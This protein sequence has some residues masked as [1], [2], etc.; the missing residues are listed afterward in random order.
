LNEAVNRDPNFALAWCLLARAHDDVYHQDGDRT[1]SRRVAAENALQHALQLRPDLG[2][3]HL[4]E[5]FHLLVTTRD[6]P[7]VRNELEIARSTLPNSASLYGLLAKVDARQGRWKDALQDLEKALSLDPKNVGFAIERY[8]LYQFHRQ[9]DE[10]SRISN[11]LV[12]TGPI[13][14]S[15]AIEKALTA[16]QAAGDT[17]PF[18]ALLDEPVGPLRDIG[19]ATLLKIYCAFADR[20][21]PRAEQILAQDPKHEFEGGDIRFVCRDWVLGWIKKMQSD[22]GAA[23]A[24]FANARPVQAA[25]V[26]KM[27]DDP[28]PLIMLALTDAAL[29]RKQEAFAEA[30]K[31]MKMRPLSRDAV[32][33]PLVASDLAQVYLWGGEPELA[34]KQL[35]TL[36]EVPRALTY[37]DLAKSPEWDPLRSDPRFQKLLSR[38][39][40]PIP[41]TNRAASQ[42]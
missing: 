41:I 34:I 30:E 5:G 35:E 21:F 25:Y 12:S 36:E 1:D 6:Y 17:A 28:N 38:V 18:H 27:P 23:Q 37:G 29:G 8:G 10:L 3:V 40:E 26:E 22:E 39:K 20:N 11:E 15:I 4:A 24:A 14:Q 32:E 16:W 31:A 9:Y 33:A 7:T 42:N 19:R 13:T 2:E